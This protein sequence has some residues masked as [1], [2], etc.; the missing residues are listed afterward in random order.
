MT[1]PAFV[2]E[3]WRVH[4]GASA[5]AVINRYLLLAGRSAANRPVA[6]ATVDRWDRRTDARPLH[7][8]CSIMMNVT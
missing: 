2:A 1:L 5:P 8:S 6:T 4:H 7:R 3:R